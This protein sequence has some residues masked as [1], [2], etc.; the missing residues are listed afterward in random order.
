MRYIWDAAEDYSPSLARRIGLA[1]FGPRLRAWD[2]ERSGRVDY[3]IANSRFVAD[4]IQSVYRRDA[5]LIYP[6]VDTDFYGG[7]RNPMARG[8]FLSVGALVG[9]KRFDLAVEAFNRLGRAS[10]HRG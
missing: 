5:A 4:R 8:F 7:S 2:R 9:Y 6:P 1:L 3:F 10:H